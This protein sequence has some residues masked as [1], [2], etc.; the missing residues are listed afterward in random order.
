MAEVV[1]VALAVVLVGA[2]GEAEVLVGLFEAPEGV[3]VAVAVLVTVAVA[4]VVPSRWPSS[5]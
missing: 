2:L 3:A 1:G 5:W 4:V